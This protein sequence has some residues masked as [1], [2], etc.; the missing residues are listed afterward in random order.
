MRP[1]IGKGRITFQGAIQIIRSLF[2]VAADQPDTGTI[3]EECCPTR[4]KCDGPIICSCRPPQITLLRKQVSHIIPDIT[5]LRIKPESLIE[6]IEG[7]VIFA[8]D[9]SENPKKS[10]DS[11]VARIELESVIEIF[12]SALEI[13]HPLPRQSAVTP[14]HNLPRF[15]GD[16]QVVIAERCL[17]VAPHE[18]DVSPIESS[19][20]LLRIKFKRSGK[21]IKGTVIITLAKP[22]HRAIEPG[23]CRSRIESDCQIVITDRAFDLTFLKPLDATS[24][25]RLGRISA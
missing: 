13:I 15:D 2:Q 7:S 5:Q 11:G 14:S 10:P 12:Q 21:I 19:G 16:G 6:A 1:C 23:C 22:R 4:I 25:I 8:P 17:I 20:E 3:I 9:P 24:D 18:K